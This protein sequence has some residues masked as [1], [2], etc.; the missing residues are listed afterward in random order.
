VILGGRLGYVLFYK[1]LYYLAHPLEILS[2]W[3]GG[4]SFHGGFLGV[5][6]ALWFF[7][8]SRR[9]RWLDVTD[10]VA[11]LVP[12]GLA[13][14]R[15]GNFI[16]GELWG[17]V[18][19]LPW[20]MVFPPAGPLPRH[21]SQL[22]QLGLEGL[23][24]FA[25]LWIYTRRRRPL[26]AASGLFLVGY[27]LARFVAEYAREPDSFLGYLALGLTMGQWLSLPMIVAGV[28][29]M[30]WAYRRADKDEPT[31]LDRMK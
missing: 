23:A 18:T 25:L 10:F 2:V 22:Y 9:K 14:G 12:L 19:D 11:P 27:G 6:V 29:M 13:A 24:L 7:A 5:L 28:V 30:R 1:P 20:A 17:R 31:V 3:Q 16:N 4:M 15:L 26:G 8:R 21:P